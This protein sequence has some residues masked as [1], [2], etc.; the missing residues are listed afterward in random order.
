MVL[1]RFSN[2]DKLVL[3]GSHRDPELKFHDFSMT[4]HDHFSEFHDFETNQ[5]YKCAASTT[6]ATRSITTYQ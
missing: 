6:P 1:G 4:S 5:I 2:I 3:Q